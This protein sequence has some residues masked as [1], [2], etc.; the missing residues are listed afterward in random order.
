[1]PTVTETPV[2]G[3]VSCMDPRCQGYK[4]RARGLRRKQEFPY[5]ELGGD[6]PGNEREAID[7]AGFADDT[8]CPLCGGP[9]D[10]GARRS[11]PEYPRS[12]G[13]TRSRC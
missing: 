8:P 7:A 2:S 1:M 6:L 9:Q 4:Q 11:A 10:R 3:Y 5:R 13:R 12:A